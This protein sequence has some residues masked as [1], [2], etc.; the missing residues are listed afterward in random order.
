MEMISYWFHWGNAWAMNY[1][2][3]DS[4]RVDGLNWCDF[5][6][7][8]VA[9][10]HAG[11]G[12]LQIGAVEGSRA[13]V[14]SGP[15]RQSRSHPGS[16]HLRQTPHSH[17]NFF[18][19]LFPSIPSVPSIPSIRS[20]RLLWPFFRFDATFPHLSLSL[21]LSLWSLP[22]IPSIP[23]SFPNWFFGLADSFH[24]MINCWLSW[25]F[26]LGIESVDGGRGAVP[27]CQKPGAQRCQRLPALRSVTSS[28]AY[29]LLICI[30]CP[31]SIHQRPR[32]S[33]FHLAPKLPNKKK[34]PSSWN[35][36]HV[37]RWMDSYGLLSCWWTSVTWEAG[38]HLHMMQMSGSGGGPSRP[39]API[40]PPLRRFTPGR[41][42]RVNQL[43]NSVH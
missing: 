12:L 31:H 42:P 23:F 6:T 10:Q 7:I 18:D 5:G 15:H 41:A 34:N 11:R 36:F 43:F 17:R 27:A 9:V 26:C 22:L 38:S 14:P 21:S 28:F 20:I 19:F 8:A 32:P 16:P 25:S 3:G 13:L 2:D 40:S 24:R 37:I 35:S 4:G 39:P 30:S 1:I 29:H 33:S